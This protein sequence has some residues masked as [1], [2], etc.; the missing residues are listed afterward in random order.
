MKYIVA[1]FKKCFYSPHTS[2][3]RF[4]LRHTCRQI[5][6]NFCCFQGNTAITF[7]RF[8][9]FLSNKIDTLG[10]IALKNKQPEEFNKKWNNFI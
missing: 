1:P 6:I 9:P 4:K 2:I 10:Q 7:D 8:P 3:C 5:L